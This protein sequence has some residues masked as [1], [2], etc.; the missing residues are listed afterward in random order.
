[1]IEE[2]RGTRACW[3]KK[4]DSILIPKLVSSLTFSYSLTY[5][6]SLSLSLSV[7]LSHSRSFPSKSKV[8]RKTPSFSP[9]SGRPLNTK[10]KVCAFCVWGMCKILYLT[11]STILNLTPPKKKKSDEGPHPPLPSTHSSFNFYFYFFLT[12]KLI[13]FKQL[14][15][16]PHHPCPLSNSTPPIQLALTSFKMGP[17]PTLLTLQ[18]PYFQS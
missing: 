1:M 6:P 4:P 9:N 7:I 14:P 3:L 2:R 8:L 17:W 12:T 13:H 15:L 16:T 18:M 10:T 11:I 5:G